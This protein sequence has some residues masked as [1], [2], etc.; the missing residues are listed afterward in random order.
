MA[1]KII[2]FFLASSIKDLA[3]DRLVVGDFVNQL[4][5]IYDTSDIF[6]KLYKCESETLD[7]SL[8]IE[9]SQASLD[10]IIK[11]SDMCFVIFWRKP[12]GVTFQE[13]KMAPEANGKFNKPKIDRKKL[14]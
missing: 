12:G 3:Y 7:H 11:S 8:K 4:N 10:E 14:V 6:I 9:G 1:K 2:S 13:L 5:N